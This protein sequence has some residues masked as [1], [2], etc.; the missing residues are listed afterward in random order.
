MDWARASPLT[1]L[2]LKVRQ[3]NA[4]AIH[5]YQKLGFLHEAT[6]KAE[7]FDGICY[8]DIHY[9]SIMLTEAGDSRQAASR[10]NFDTDHDD[11]ID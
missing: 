8:H 9:M 11:F 4:R 6:L 3:D 2:V 1:K 5:L 7:I 10:P